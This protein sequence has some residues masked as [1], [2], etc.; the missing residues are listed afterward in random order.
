MHLYLYV[1]GLPQWVGIW[2]AFAQSQFYKWR[3]IDTRTGQEQLSLVQGALRKSVLGTYEYVF[4]K[5][6]L[7]TVIAMMR[8]SGVGMS[9]EPTL[10]NKINLMTL[11][12]MIGCKKIPK[13][14]F[15]DAKEISTSIVINDNER[16][17]SDFS[18]VP[19]ST[20]I[21][22]IKNDK[23]GD[24]KDFDPETKEEMIW[25]QELL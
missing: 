11:R 19:V 18:G 4:P 9:V 12:K 20:H 17:L 21:I 10:K 16:G 5:E 1:R 6:A 14:I 24:M 22:G 15:K 23:V 7:A 2:E 25:F 8:V 13:K 3:R